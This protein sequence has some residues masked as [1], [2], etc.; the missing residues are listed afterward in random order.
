LS[1]S[2]TTCTEAIALARRVLRHAGVRGPEDIDVELIA[3]DYGITSIGKRLPGHAGNLVRLGAS[4]RSLVAIDEAAF[5]APMGRFT[6]AHE[7]GHR[8]MHVGSGLALACTSEPRTRDHFRGEREADVFAVEIV[9]P[10]ELVRA[11]MR[12]GDPTLAFVRGVATTFRTSLSATALRFL[13]FSRHACA[14]VLS[15]GG[16]IVKHAAT[17]TFPLRL[18]RGF[19][20]GRDAF[21]Y[22]AEALEHHEGVGAPERVPGD[23]WCRMAKAKRM[24]VVEHSIRLGSGGLVLTLLTL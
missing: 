8:L 3:F 18:V 2:R 12:V 17:D 13:D 16:S 21:A 22:A 11:H 5:G 24:H 20:I 15:R 9:L 19:A 14:V 1:L 7:L 6:L 4:E 23:A 10:E